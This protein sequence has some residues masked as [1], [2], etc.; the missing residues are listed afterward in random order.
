M[1]DGE[2]TNSGADAQSQ[3]A[4]GFVRM[5]LDKMQIE[6]EA[7]LAPDDGEGS[8]DEI[9]IDIEGPDAGRVIGKRGT[10]LEAI[11]Y[12]TT[13]IVHR[14]G[15]ARRHVQVDAEGYR[16]RHEDQLAEMAKKLGQRVAS[17]GKVITFDP[18]SARDR[19]I[20]HVALKD[21]TGVR[22]ESHGEG[23]DRRVQI[24][25]LKSGA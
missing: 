19:R 21:V 3:R 2:T 17:E 10:V 24:I 18:M 16:A 7:V 11:Q 14:P 12:L 1:T 8:A 4:V 22:T 15:D 25:P 5:L 23:P 20:V 6:A 13:R 9:R